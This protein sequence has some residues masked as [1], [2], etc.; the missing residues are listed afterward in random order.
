MHVSFTTYASG[1]SRL[2][3]QFTAQK[4]INLE[5]TFSIDCLFDG[6]SFIEVAILE[7]AD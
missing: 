6:D 4:F 5:L 1:R 7:V 2:V 3:S